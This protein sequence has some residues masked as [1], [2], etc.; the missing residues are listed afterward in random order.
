[1]ANRKFHNITVEVKG[2]PAKYIDG[3]STG[4]IAENRYTIDCNFPSSKIKEKCIKG[5]AIYVNDVKYVPVNKI[6]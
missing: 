6:R 3:D 2:I 5:I 4:D 1:M